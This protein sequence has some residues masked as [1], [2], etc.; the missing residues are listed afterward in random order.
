MPKR[1]RALRVAGALLVVATVASFFASTAVMSFVPRTYRYT[2]PYYET[3]A[4]P[5]RVGTYVYDHSR[6]AAYPDYW[7]DVARMVDRVLVDISWRTLMKNASYPGCFDEARLAFYDALCRNISARGL[8]VVIQFSPTRSPPAWLNVTLE[9]H[10]YRAENPPQDPVERA[11]FTEMLLHYVNRTVTFF[12]GK[13][14]FTE[15][16]Y[17]LADEPH[18]ADWADV[19]QA[20]YDCI[21]AASTRTVS[22]VLNKPDLYA[23]F[24]TAF[25]LITIDPYNDDHEMVQKIERAHAA[26]NYSKPVRVIISGMRSGSGAFDYQRVR[27]QLVIAW[28]TGAHDVW[29]WAYNAHWVARDKEWYVVQFAEDGPVYTPRADAVVN[30]RQDLRIFGEI[31]AALKGPSP[32]APAVASRLRALESRAYGQVMRNNF[33]SARRTLLEA[34]NLLA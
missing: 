19:L 15:L 5:V 18:T 1:A 16:E 32:P 2:P 21:K 9:M 10:G 23:T 20:M 12:E 24:T 29:F 30:A 28:F 25:D 3:T 27:R 4:R 6:M 13:S 14:Y 17:C 34:H 31:E 7:D 33:G 22:L 8:G 26:V 11:H